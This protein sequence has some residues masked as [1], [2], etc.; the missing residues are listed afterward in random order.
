MA[1]NIIQEVYLKFAS[2]P[3]LPQKLAMANSTV[4]DCRISTFLARID[5]GLMKNS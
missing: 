5:K 4:K 2:L 3:R 1:S